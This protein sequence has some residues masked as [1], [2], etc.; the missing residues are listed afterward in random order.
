M[1]EDRN[2]IDGGLKSLAKSLMENK[3]VPCPFV[4]ADGRKCKGHIIKVEAYKADLEWEFEKLYQRKWSGATLWKFSFGPRSHYHL[5]CSEKGNH[6]GPGRED[7]LK[8]RF[9]ELPKKI[10]DV[11]HRTEATRY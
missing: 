11:I 3:L 4:Y 8:Y 6:A 1:A 5:F 2:K 10:K 9:S 7:R